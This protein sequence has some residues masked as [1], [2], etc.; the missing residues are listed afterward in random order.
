M[1]NGRVSRHSLTTIPKSAFLLDILLTVT[2]F[3]VPPLMRSAL[4]SGRNEM[5]P[6]A[7][8]NPELFG[9]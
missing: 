5:A 6:Q 4:F 3:E 8:A 7:W 9:T 1:S 2:R